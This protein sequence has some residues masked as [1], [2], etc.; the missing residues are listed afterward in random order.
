DFG[1]DLKGFYIDTFMKIT[2]LQNKELAQRCKETAWSAVSYITHHHR[3][4]VF[5]GVGI[6]YNKDL[7]SLEEI[8]C[9]GKE[10]HTIDPFLQT[11]AMSYFNG[12]YRSKIVLPS[13][14]EMKTVHTLL[15]EAGLKT[16]QAFSTE[17]IPPSEK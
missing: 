9:I 8:Q 5:L 16:V 17:F 6:P 7:I 15:Q 14:D 11:T 2:G 10:L 1:I 12:Y 13:F 3:E 4:K